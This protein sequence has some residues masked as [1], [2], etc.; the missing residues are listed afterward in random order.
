MAR[1]KK[2]TEA[3][4]SGGDEA[5]VAAQENP[6]VQR[7]IDDADLRGELHR[8]ATA[9][10][11]A[12]DRLGSGK[13]ATAKA[14]RDDDQLPADLHTAL[15]SLGA[16]VAKLGKT[17]RGKRSKPDKP[18]GG[19]VPKLTLLTLAGGIALATNEGLRSKVLDAL[20]GAE[21]EF[22]YTPPPAPVPDAP[23][24]PDSPVSAV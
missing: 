19:L 15:D 17:K 2:A 9:T 16:T 20:F 14:L 24:S 5:T 10:A 23:S 4:A 18:R 7:L 8:A 6:L 12:L 1:R 21:E 11:K 22:Q 3:V 13:R